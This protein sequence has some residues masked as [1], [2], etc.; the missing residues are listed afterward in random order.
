[1]SCK[2]S[3]CTIRGLQLLAMP[4]LAR[5]YRLPSDSSVSITC[6]LIE[7]NGTRNDDTFF[8]A[9]VLASG[10]RSRRL[11]YCTQGCSA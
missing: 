10:G 2:I 8:E 1:M 6:R 11:A 9:K 5:H 4:D 3:H 7:D